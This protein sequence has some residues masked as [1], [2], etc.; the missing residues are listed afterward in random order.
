[1]EHG[2]TAVAIVMARGGSKGIPKKNL[3]LLRGK[4]LIQ[5]A[6]ESGLNCPEVDRVIVSTDS[7]E[8]AD[9]ARKCGAEV[10]FLRPAELAQ[11]DTP[12]RP[13][14]VHLIKWLK[15]NENYE[16]AYLVNLRC[17]TPLRQPFHVSE[18][19]GVVTGC[20]CDSLRTV[21][22]IQGKHHPY[23]MLKMDENGFSAPFVDGIST[24]KYHQ[25]QLLPPAYSINALVDVIKVKTALEAESLYGKKM[26]ILETDPIYSVDI[27]TEEDLIICSAIMEKLNLLIKKK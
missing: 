1:M 22:K 20:D 16:F 7:P 21:D 14:M 25:R 2:K 4:P 19:M 6:I 23:W 12:D 26:K 17:T 10:P 9:A 5:H 18:A 27:D 15:E 11:S 24:V 8:I 13:V 3:S